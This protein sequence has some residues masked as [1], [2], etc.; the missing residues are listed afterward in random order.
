MGRAGKIKCLRC[1]ASMPRCAWALDVMKC[2]R[3][4]IAL[5][6]SLGLVACQSSVPIAQSAEVKTYAVDA[7]RR[8]TVLSPDQLKR[9]N[10]WLEQRKSDW[11]GGVLFAWHTEF[12][13]Q[14][15][16]A[17]GNCTTLGIVARSVLASNNR[18]EFSQVISETEMASL[19]TALG[20]P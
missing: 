13:V 20:V 4:L 18:G 16:H 11:E 19:R 5:I 8:S 9:L 3:A 17:D 2:G 15:V 1:A 14:L 6:V 12:E 7:G 10:A